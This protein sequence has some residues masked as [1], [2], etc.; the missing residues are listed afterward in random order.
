MQFVRRLEKANLRAQEPILGGQ[1][2][3]SGDR[4]ARNLETQPDPTREICQFLFHV[5]LDA[6]SMVDL[7]SFVMLK[8]V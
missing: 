6:F 1:F 8:N 2:G 5:L 3:R 7:R 4:K